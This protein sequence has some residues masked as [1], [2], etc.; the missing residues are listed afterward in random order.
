MLVKVEPELWNV[1]L[2]ITLLCIEKG[3]A[4]LTKLQGVFVRSPA[5]SRHRVTITLPKLGKAKQALLTGQEKKRAQK[6]QSTWAQRLIRV[7][8]TDI[9]TCELCACARV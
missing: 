2:H 7:F 4:N 1:Y 6:H 5:N 8:N 3:Q 9:E